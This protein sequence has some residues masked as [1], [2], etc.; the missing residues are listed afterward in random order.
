MNEEI[1]SL[2]SYSKAKKYEFFS[3]STFILVLYKFYV[4]FLLK[5]RI[6]TCVKFL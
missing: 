4:R 6:K 1:L 3:T 2:A 5:F